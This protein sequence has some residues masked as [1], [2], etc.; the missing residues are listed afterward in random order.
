MRLATQVGS[1]AGPESEFVD[2]DVTTAVQL[3]S[4]KATDAERSAFPIP[5]TTRSVRSDVARAMSQVDKIVNHVV[6]ILQ[7]YVSTSLL[8]SARVLL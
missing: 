5:H 6:E 2:H 3:R 1:P 7:I 4:Y 8:L